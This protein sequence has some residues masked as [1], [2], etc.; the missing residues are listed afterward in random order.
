MGFLGEFIQE[1]LSLVIKTSIFKII[2]GIQVI[3]K[4][5]LYKGEYYKPTNIT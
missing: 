1:N 2:Q 5:A 4:Q 3:Q